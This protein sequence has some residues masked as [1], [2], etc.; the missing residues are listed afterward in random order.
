MPWP[1]CHPRGLAT[2][3][4]RLE[5][6]FDKLKHPVTGPDLERKP[7]NRRLTGDELLTMGPSKPSAPAFLRL[8]TGDRSRFFP[9]RLASV[10]KTR[11]IAS[12][13]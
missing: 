10:N 13:V 2:G 9:R 8:Q 5:R 3:D 4:W 6:D 7:S 12:I 1:L 11:L